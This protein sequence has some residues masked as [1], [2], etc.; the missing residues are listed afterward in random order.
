M[1]INIYTYTHTH[2]DIHT[3]TYTHIHAASTHMQ[4]HIHTFIH[5]HTHTHNVSSRHSYHSLEG[6]NVW[7]WWPSPM[8]DRVLFIRG[9]STFAI[10]P[11]SLAWSSWDVALVPSPQLQ[12]PQLLGE[13]ASS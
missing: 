4:T 6:A 3:S 11:V 13:A 7:R 5:T 2:I 9:S 8:P 10:L 12:E 1:H